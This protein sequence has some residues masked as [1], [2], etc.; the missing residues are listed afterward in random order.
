MVA[1]D[2]DEHGPGDC[3]PE[4]SEPT[5]LVPFNVYIE[6]AKSKKIEIQIE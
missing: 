4:L 1:F 3:L 2:D 5:S 6:L